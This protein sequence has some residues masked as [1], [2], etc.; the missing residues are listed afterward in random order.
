MSQLID[1]IIDL[2]NLKSLGNDQF[3]GKN[4]PV[5]KQ[6]IFGGQIIAQLLVAANNTIEDKIA[7]SLKC[8][9]LRPG[10]PNIPVTY[11]VERL[12]DGRS[13]SSRR[14][15][16]IQN[17]K[18]IATASVSFHI[19]EDG[20][21]HQIDME[22]GINPEELDSMLDNWNKIKDT[23]PE[24]MKVWHEPN[25]PFEERNVEWVNPIE[26][27]IRKPYHIAWFKSNG[28]VPDNLQLQ[29]ALFAYSSDMQLM[30]SCL[31][32]HGSPWQ[33][34]TSASLDHCIWFHKP[35]KV[36]QWYCLIQNSPFSGGARG[37]NKS[38]VY[39]QS[40]ELVASL[41]QEALIRE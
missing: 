20:L 1:Q 35:F 4:N 25:R 11:I 23:I 31:L 30:E 19:Q 32:P 41:S 37:L 26:L 24:Q 28:K 36:D 13:F 14:V 10:N 6:R 27:K 39:T 12:R 34:I 7:H 5:Y 33:T 22:N 16:A 18:I 2:L 17:D 29:Q 15:N 40:G 3:I 38:L 9:F 8:D 21:S